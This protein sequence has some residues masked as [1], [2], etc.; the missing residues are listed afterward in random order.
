MQAQKKTIKETFDNINLSSCVDA[1]KLI[2]GQSEKFWVSSEED[3]LHKLAQNLKQIA[4]DYL[5]S[6]DTF[7]KDLLADLSEYA[8]VL[9]QQLVL[10]TYDSS[11]EEIHN[12]I[13]REHICLDNIQ[14]SYKNFIQAELMNSLKI[15][16]DEARVLIELERRNNLIYDDF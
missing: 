6:G 7:R 16:Y 4:D 14:R 11:P 2:F 15:G 10:D 3:K 5:R 12:Y 13:Q 9:H 1:I 8:F